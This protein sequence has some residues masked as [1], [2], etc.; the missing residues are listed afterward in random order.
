MNKFKKLLLIF[1]FSIID[2]FI[3]FVITHLLVTTNIV[4][5]KNYTF[6]ISNITLE[7]ILFVTL[8]FIINVFLQIFYK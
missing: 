5:S 3:A 7:F 8:L 4:T 1:V 6:S 2:M